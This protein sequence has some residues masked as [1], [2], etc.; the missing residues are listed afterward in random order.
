MLCSNP[1]R[2]ASRLCAAA[3]AGILSKRKRAAQ[4]FLLVVNPTAAKCNSL[5]LLEYHVCQLQNADGYAIVSP[6][7]W[8]ALITQCTC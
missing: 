2:D 3:A 1:E 4:S 6:I 5:R 7:I 8:E